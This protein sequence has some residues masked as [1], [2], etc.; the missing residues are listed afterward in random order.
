MRRLLHLMAAQLVC[1]HRNKP[2]VTTVFSVAFLSLVIYRLVAHP[3]LPSCQQHDPDV[4]A[5]F[6]DKDVYEWEWQN[7]T[8]RDWILS[9]LAAGTAITA[10]L[11]NAFSSHKQAETG[12]DR[13]PP[14]GTASVTVDNWVMTFAA[15][16]VIATTLDSKMRASTQAERYRRGDLILQYAPMDYLA[17][18]DKKA[19]LAPWHKESWREFQKHWARATIRNRTQVRR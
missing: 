16:T 10:A 19:L 18:N 8:V 1:C 5:I 12:N 3:P 15:L 14:R 7:W 11:K 9:L 13:N 6:H 4:A 17:N 2:K